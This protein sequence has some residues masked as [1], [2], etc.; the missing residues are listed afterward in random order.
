MTHGREQFALQDRK[1]AHYADVHAGVRQL[2]ADGVPVHV[3]ETYAARRS[4][5]AEDFP[6]YVDVAPAG[7][8]QIRSY[9][10]LGYVLIRVR[11]REAGAPRP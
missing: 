6:A 3:C 9:Q 7:P 5:S 11:P 4:V 10:E 8:T 1:A 2:S